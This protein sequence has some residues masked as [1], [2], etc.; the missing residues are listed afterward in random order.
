MNSPN[1][2]PFRHSSAS[3]PMPAVSAIACG[4]GL[5][6][7]VVMGSG[8]RPGAMFPVARRPGGCALFQTLRSDRPAVGPH[9]SALRQN[10]ANPVRQA[11]F[12]FES[13]RFALESGAIITIYRGS[14]PCANPYS[15]L[16]FSPF[17]WPAACR[18]PLLAGWR[19]LLPEPPSRMRLTRIS[20]PEP[21]SARWPVRPHAGSNWACRPANPATDLIAPQGQPSHID[22][23]VRAHRPAGPVLHFARPTVRSTACS[24]PA[25]FLG[26]PCS[27]KS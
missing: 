7:P 10:N 16:P 2:L 8:N 19:V 21:L 1:A 5:R 27:R 12:P 22:G 18:I 9:F 23:V 14:K 17:L 6:H 26:D 15:S 11:I 25:H 13:R 24:G 3:G 20:S 4:S